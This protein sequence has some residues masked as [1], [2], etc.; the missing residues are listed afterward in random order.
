MSCLKA[1]VITALMLSC[2]TAVAALKNPRNVTA[3]ALSDSEIELTWTSRGGSTAGFFANVRIGTRYPKAYC[4]PGGSITNNKGLR[5]DAGNNES[6]V[7]S[8]LEAEQTYSFRVATYD[9]N[10]KTSK[11]ARIRATTLE[12]VVQPPEPPAEILFQKTIDFSGIDERDALRDAKLDAQGRVV[13]VGYVADQDLGYTRTD[14]LA[15]R[16]DLNGNLDSTFGDNGVAII[17][18]GFDS[19]RGYELAFDSL[20]R[21]VVCG[22]TINTNASNTNA[23][24]YETA[25]VRLE[26]DG[27]LDASFAD[28]GVAINSFHS[29]YSDSWNLAVG[30]DDS[31][32]IGGTAGLG[33][34]GTLPGNSIE[35]DAL[36]AHLSESGVLL[37]SKLV[38]LGG[39]E[40]INAI[41]VDA[42]GQLIAAGRSDLNGIPASVLMRFIEING[43]V[44]LDTSFGIDGVVFVPVNAVGHWIRRIKFDVSGSLLATGSTQ[45]ADGTADLAVFKFDNHGDLDASF[46]DAGVTIA[47]LSAGHDKGYAITID[48]LGRV[49]VG[50]RTY[51]DGNSDVA[52]CRFNT[53]GTIDTTFG[54]EGTGLLRVAPTENDDHVRGIVHDPVTGQAVVVGHTFPTVYGDSLIIGFDNGDGFAP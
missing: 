42:N 7:I 8:G 48:N 14:F 12:E 11:G 3:T 52:I 1:L 39:Y 43:E 10:G 32:W 37:G 50:G 49:L 9:S 16:F 23:S 24:R 46:G 28:A 18:L 34:G 26:V 40:R 29:S 33:A 13:A 45:N 35:D 41:A 6:I 19:D 51:V 30:A 27:T 15:V 38:D 25:V 22:N 44:E 21:I 54:G 17:D 47:P 31:I 36:V 5:F 2:S 4:L 53:D 20:G